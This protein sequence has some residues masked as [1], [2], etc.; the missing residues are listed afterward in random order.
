[1]STLKKLQHYMGNRRILLPLSMLLSAL[2]ALAGLLPFILVWLIVRELLGAG[3]TLV[4]DNVVTY[5]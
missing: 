1:M 5:V 3:G 4:S 2:S